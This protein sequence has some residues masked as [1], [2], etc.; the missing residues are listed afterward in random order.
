MNKKTKTIIWIVVG[1]I[2]LILAA[3]LLNNLLN[4]GQAL[5]FNAFLQKLTTGEINTIYVDGYS[6][7]GTGTGGVF[8]TVAPSLYGMN[9]YFGLCEFLK[10]KGVAD[11]YNSINISMTDPNAG[12]FLSSLMPIIGIVVVSLIFFFIMKNASGAPGSSANIGKNKANVQSNLK[13]RFSDV[14]V[15]PVH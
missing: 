6:W 7:R 13:V 14:A 4:A 2:G 1:V 3:T 12:S 11:P 15:V 8:N 5:T 10:G 9:D